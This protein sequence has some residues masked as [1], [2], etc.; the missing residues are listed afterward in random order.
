MAIQEDAAERNARIKALAVGAVIVGG[1]YMIVRWY[2]T[3]SIAELCEYNPMLGPNLEI[4]GYHIYPP[5]AYNAWIADEKLLYLIPDIFDKFR[6]YPLISF[7]GSVFIAYVICK[8]MTIDISHGSARFATLKDI[9]AA[10]LGIYKTSN[11]GNPDYIKSRFTF[12]GIPTPFFIKKKQIKRHGV[13]VGVNPYNHRLMLHD[14]PE[15]ILLMAPTRSGKGVST[16]IPTGITWAHSIFFFD[17]KAELWQATAAY[18]QKNLK[19]KV[20][21]FQPLCSDG[22]A[23]RWNPF[24]EINYRT[25][26]EWGDVTT[27]VNIMIKPD[28]DK[29]GGSDPF[30][31]NSSINLLVGVF[32]HLLY[33]HHHDQRPLPCPTDIMSFLSS[34][35]MSLKKLFHIM[36]TYQHIHPEEFLELPYKVT[37]ENGNEI[38]PENGKEWRYKNPLKEIYGE[39]IKDFADY[40]REMNL[41]V[42]KITTIDELRNAI[43]KYLENPDNKIDWTPPEYNE[44]DEDCS[45]DKTPWHKLLTH[46]RVAE[47]AA[48]IKSGAEQTSASILQTAQASLAVY[49]DPVVQRNTAVSDFSIRDLLDPRQ[50]VSVYFVLEVKD[51]K[52]VRP[53]ARLFIDVLLSKL[54]KDMKFEVDAEK[55]KNQKKQ[56]LLLMLDEFPQLGNLPSVESAMAICAGYGIKM[57]IV[58]QDINQL[59]KAYTK[60]N[61]VASN[62][63]VHIYFTPNNETSAGSGTAKAISEQLGKKTIKSVSHSDGGG[64]FG[65]G[66][67]STSAQG[68]ELMTP[69][70]VAKMSSEKELVFVAGHN[71]IYGD[72]LRYYKHSEFLKVILP[73]PA[74]SDT[75]T[76]IHD[77]DQLFEVHKAET[78]ER[79]DK[80]KE[81]AAAKAQIMIQSK[82]HDPKKTIRNIITIGNTGIEHEENEE[83]EDK[84]P[85]GHYSNYRQG[86]FGSKYAA[87]PRM[88]ENPWRTNSDEMNSSED[89][90][91]D[92]QDNQRRFQDYRNLKSDKQQEENNQSVPSA[93][94]CSSGSIVPVEVP[95]IQLESA[96]TAKEA[97]ISVRSSIEEPILETDVIRLWEKHY[98]E[99]IKTEN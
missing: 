74:F 29:Q 11:G 18:R 94:E 28:G 63:H 88:G 72:K 23:C 35:G 70:E 71:P 85:K 1:V 68:R 57:C 38:K 66:S 77:F 67:D 53:I 14:G 41:P 65:K 64:G 32:V 75:A 51:I 59:N 34:P 5:L 98:H 92:E 19:Q 13:V 9:D 16:I 87:G 3:Q 25:M 15:H 86:E 54:I 47:A 7:L 30:W 73:P 96:S 50:E 8:D 89:M 45:D 21:K 49:R 84:R 40:E 60:D 78:E 39:Y 36:M 17:P 27:L 83:T 90:N 97:E 79:E 12:L 58:C 24:G 2:I 44:D 61:S 69:D 82:D 48:N 55:Q 46:P 56:R 95:V 80:R 37:D 62:C 31:D 10:D 6:L 4:L 91:E 43:N 93:E 99:L 22:S 76:A 33:K 20:L 42:G 26:E 52:T 81:V